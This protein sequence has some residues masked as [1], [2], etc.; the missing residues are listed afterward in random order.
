M[1]NA[2]SLAI[3]MLFITFCS[4]IFTSIIRFQFEVSKL[5]DFHYS[6]V[7]EIESSDF[8]SAV[9]SSVKNNGKYTV[10]VENVTSKEDLGIYQ[11]KTSRTLKMPIFN[12][13]VDYVK[14]STAR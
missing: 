3:S 6:A 4:V 13:S 10:E 1:K 9:I 2:I 11:I 7:N 8:S 5:E 12:Y 14:E